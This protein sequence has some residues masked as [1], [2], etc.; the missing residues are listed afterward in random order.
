MC[1]Q[2]FS[3]KGICDA[4]GVC[5]GCY[6]NLACGASSNLTCGRNCQFVVSQDQQICVG[7]K[8][9]GG[10]LPYCGKLD[11]IGDNSRWACVG[12]YLTPTFVPSSATATLAS[13]CFVLLAVAI[14][15]AL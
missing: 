3:D 1:A 8:A 15:S 9:C 13:V 4:T 11:G 7:G 14:H 5:M 6:T 10:T 2:M 12:P